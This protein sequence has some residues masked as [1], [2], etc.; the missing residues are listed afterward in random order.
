MGFRW[1]CY[2]GMYGQRAAP[3]AAARQSKGDGRSLARTVFEPERTDHG[4]GTGKVPR[5]RQ[6]KLS[7]PSSRAARARRAGIKIVGN[8][9]VR[10]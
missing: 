8:Y 2:S 6:R 4:M 10:P 9:R 5:R 3:F 7:G 1:E